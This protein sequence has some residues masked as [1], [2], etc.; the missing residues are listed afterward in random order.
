MS[1]QLLLC[2]CV[3]WVWFWATLVFLYRYSVFT[4]NCGKET[5]YISGSCRGGPTM[6]II[7]IDIVH[8]KG[9]IQW[10]C[11]RAWVRF[12]W[13]SCNANEYIYISYIYIDVY[14]SNETSLRNIIQSQINAW[15]IILS[16]P[17]EID[18]DFVL[19]LVWKCLIFF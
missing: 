1:L 7:D 13:R 19:V 14:L 15:S 4:G 17:K 12:Y 6:K 8:T 9:S 11:S 2:A 3:H 16:S 18:R 10:L 5:Y